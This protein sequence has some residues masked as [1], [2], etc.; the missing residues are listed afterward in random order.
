MEQVNKLFLIRYP[1]PRTSG[2]TTDTKLYKFPMCALYLS[3]SNSVFYPVINLYR[4]KGIKGVY[5]ETKVQNVLDGDSIVLRELGETTLTGKQIMD[6]MEESIRVQSLED[7]YFMIANTMATWVK[8]MTNKD[9]T[10]P[11]ILQSEY[12]G[13]EIVNSI[14]QRNIDTKQIELEENIR[15]DFTHLPRFNSNVE[16]STTC[17]VA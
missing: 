11:N 2:D 7:V 12:F 17:I 15:K 14:D 9:V 3:L 16:S 6:M 5:I 13:V 4:D 1:V 8:Y 10:I